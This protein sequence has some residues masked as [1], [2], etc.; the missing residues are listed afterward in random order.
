VGIERV[1]LFF[2]EVNVD[3]GGERTIIWTWCWMFGRLYPTFN[4]R[5]ATLII[6]VLVNE[7]T[8]YQHRL[9]KGAIKY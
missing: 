1:M 5:S 3:G 4:S 2:G 7:S 8:S 9:E 6:S